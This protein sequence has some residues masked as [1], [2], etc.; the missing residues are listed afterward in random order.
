MTDSSAIVVR[1]NRTKNRYEA[2]VD[3]ELAVAVYAL[4]RDTITF[5]HTEVPEQAEG[6]GVAGALVRFALDDARA[7]SLVVIPR[8]PYVTNWIKRH[9]EYHD[10]VHPDWRVFLTR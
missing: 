3:D 5:L 4:D 6:K 8:C 2:D 7:R 1:D 10:L 9:R